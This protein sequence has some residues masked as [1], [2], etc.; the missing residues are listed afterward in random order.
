ME[1]TTI[2]VD[3]A[4]DVFQVALANRAGRVIGRR[5]L[6]RRQFERWLETVGVGT[7]VVMEAQQCSPGRASPGDYGHDHG[8]TRADRPFLGWPGSNPQI[9]SLNRSVSVVD[10]TLGHGARVPSVLCRCSRSRW[11]PRFPCR[12]PVRASLNSVAVALT[13]DLSLR[14]P[15]GPCMPGLWPDLTEALAEADCSSVDRCRCLPSSRL[16]RAERGVD[17]AVSRWNAGLSP[18]TARR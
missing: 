16:V 9:T 12:H 18:R 4:K 1:A 14:P 3:L 8:A 7:D 17:H 5:R 13:G 6:T 2:A 15:P 11:A 10:P